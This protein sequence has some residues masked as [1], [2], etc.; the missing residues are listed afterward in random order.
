MR[1]RK[2]HPQ[3]PHTSADGR[4]ARVRLARWPTRHPRRLPPLT[5][6]SAATVTI[7]RIVPGTRGLSTSETSL[8]WGEEQNAPAGSGPWPEPLG[9][10]AY[11]GLAGEIVRELEPHNEA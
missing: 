2:P 4:R 3:P 7:P 8:T 1:R 6:P 5:A 11:F 9:D 10:A